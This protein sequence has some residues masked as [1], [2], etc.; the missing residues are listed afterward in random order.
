MCHTIS[1]RIQTY[2]NGQFPAIAI[3]VGVDPE[4]V[5]GLGAET[6]LALAGV[7]LADISEGRVIGGRNNL[8]DTVT[9]C[10]ATGV[11]TGVVARVGGGHGGGTCAQCT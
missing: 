4:G 2:S 7:S 5:L 6:V 3:A 11:V 9:R 10:A 8:D 1:S